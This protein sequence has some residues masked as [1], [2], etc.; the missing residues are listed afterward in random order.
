MFSELLCGIWANTLAEVHGELRTATQVDI[1]E[2]IE[3][4]IFMKY[5][6]NPSVDISY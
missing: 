1:A 6:L 2:A 4:M 5:W 3:Y